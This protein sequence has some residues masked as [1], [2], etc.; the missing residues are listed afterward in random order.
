LLKR[1]TKSDRIIETDIPSR[2]D[3]LRW[4][5]FHTRVVLALGIT[6]I[7]D[8]LE[9][10]LAGSLAGALKQSPVLHFS[11]ADV[12][13]AASAYLAGAVLGALLHVI[14]NALTKVI[15]FLSAGNIHRAY[16]S[17]RIDEVSGAL[18]RLPVSGALFLTGF[19]AITGSPPFGP[20]I[21]EFTI[22]NGAM[23]GGH[24]VAAGLFLLFLLVIFIGMG[25]TVLA[26]VQGVPPEDAEG[27]SFRESAFK[28]VPIIASLAL[29]VM[30]GVWIPAPVYAF[31]QRAA[32]MLEHAR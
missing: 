4:S 3:R 32:R 22:L 10:T 1:R 27:R 24:Y 2:L 17:K 26:V 14:N 28:T 19:L 29:V 9:V 5:G 8:G 6:W 12:G 11:N 7:L 15:L 31:V 20:F 23:L 18:R 13:L 21:S 30:M 16:G 25:S